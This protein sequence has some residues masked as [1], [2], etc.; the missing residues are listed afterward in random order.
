MSEALGLL[1][2][3]PPWWIGSRNL[4]DSD[5]R[6]F[7]AVCSIKQ[8]QPPLHNHAR[9]FTPLP[10][11]LLFSLLL[12]FSL[13][14]CHGY[15]QPDLWWCRRTCQSSALRSPDAGCLRQWPLSH[16]PSF[17]LA[18]IKSALPLCSSECLLLFC[19]QSLCLDNFLGLVFRER[20]K[21]EQKYSS[22]IQFPY[23]WRESSQSGIIWVEDGIK[24]S[25][26][27]LCREGCFSTWTNIVVDRIQ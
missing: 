19:Q 3:E 16:A 6:L 5:K 21:K 26:K 15:T 22:Q 2:I 25:V 8:H 9:F 4:T 20:K 18:L 1:V 7:G 27:S 12:H 17:N 11:P 14:C 10:S 13:H 24:L 23:P